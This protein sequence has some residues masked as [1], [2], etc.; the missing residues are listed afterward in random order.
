MT[1]LLW[2]VLAAGLVANV[3]LSLVV[4]DGGTQL[5]LSALTG[6]GVLAAATARPVGAAPQPR[7]PRGRDVSSGHGD[8]R[9]HS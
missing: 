8:S 6:L 9:I 2:T 4:P 5:L 1:S 3:L 7:G